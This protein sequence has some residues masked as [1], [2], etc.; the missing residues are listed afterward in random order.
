VCVQP[1]AKGGRLPLHLALEQKA[2]AKVVAALLE[3]N[4]GAARMATK[5]MCG[6]HA[7]AK[8]CSRMYNMCS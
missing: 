3:A 8:V 5:K 7:N 1:L 4:P 6:G 2:G